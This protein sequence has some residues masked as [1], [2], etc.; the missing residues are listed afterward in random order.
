MARIRVRRGKSYARIDD[1]TAEAIVR[2]IEDRYSEVA[3]TLEAE[4]RKLWDEA[5]SKWRVKTG[6]SKAAMRYGLEF[7]PPSSLR[8]RIYVDP[9]SPAIEY[10]WHIGTSRGRERGDWMTLV[11]DPAQKRAKELAEDLGVAF[12][13]SL[14]SNWRKGR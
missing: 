3:N 5:Q 6:R 8:S 14:Y 1:P 11:R 7:R 2:T 13:R 4:T 12:K 10:V 9:S